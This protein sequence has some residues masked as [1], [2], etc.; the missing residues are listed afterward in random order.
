MWWVFYWDTYILDFVY[1]GKV[2]RVC[3][4]VNCQLWDL[5]IVLGVKKML[6]LVFSCLCLTNL[7]LGFKYH[8]G[9]TVHF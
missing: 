8:V 1:L 4:T 5:E 2:V 9:I 7:I 3:G 6:K